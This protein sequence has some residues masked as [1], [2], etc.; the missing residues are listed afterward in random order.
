MPLRMA[1]R[2]HMA[3]VPPALGAAA[4]EDDISS[5][6]GAH[7]SATTGAATIFGVVA[8]A[9]PKPTKPPIETGRGPLPP[10][11]MVFC[12]PEEGGLGAI[13]AARDASGTPEMSEASAE[14]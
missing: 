1:L 6:I 3:Q 11:P 12:N 5:T 9:G 8:A 10:G 4:T 2:E 13:G 14:A 7:E